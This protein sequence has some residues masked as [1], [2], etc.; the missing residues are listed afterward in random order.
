MQTGSVILRY[1]WAMISML[2]AESFHKFAQS[3]AV[4]LRKMFNKSWNNFEKKL[5]AQDIS[6]GWEKEFI[7]KNTDYAA[8]RKKCFKAKML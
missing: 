2:A 5:I 6:F 3:Q 8:V 7:S 1:R 4:L